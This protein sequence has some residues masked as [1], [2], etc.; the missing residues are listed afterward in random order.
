MYRNLLLLTVLAAVSPLLVG[1]ESNSLSG[2]LWWLEYEAEATVSANTVHYTLTIRNPSA[3]TLRFMAGGCTRGAALSV[4]D[5]ESSGSVRWDQVR[6]VHE[7]VPPGEVF[8][9][10][11]LIPVTIP[12]GEEITVQG[13][14]QAWVILGDSLPEGPY[15]FRV[16][17]WFYDDDGATG[18]AIPAG[19]GVLRR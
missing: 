17:A 12:A 8:C 14:T 6:W 2:P 7:V 19:E 13:G 1:C 15:S 4:H 10:A 11:D 18:P 5:P 3:E 9:P 16:R